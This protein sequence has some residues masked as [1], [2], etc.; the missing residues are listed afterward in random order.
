MPGA[1]LL[2]MQALGLGSFGHAGVVV[3]IVREDLVGHARRGS[4]RHVGSRAWGFWP[5]RR[6]GGH[7]AGGPGRSC[8]A[9]LCSPCRL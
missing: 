1:A 3:V 4:A 9:R 8:Q 5:C 7:R 6:G 2:A